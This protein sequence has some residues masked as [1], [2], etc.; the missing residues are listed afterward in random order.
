MI[1]SDYVILPKEPS[2]WPDLLALQLLDSSRGIWSL[3]SASWLHALCISSD[4]LYIYHRGLLK[5]LWICFHRRSFPALKW[6]P[7]RRW[8][9]FGHLHFWHFWKLGRG[10]FRHNH[11]ITFCPSFWEFEEVTWRGFLWECWRAWN[12]RHMRGQPVFQGSLRQKL[13][14]TPK[15]R[16]L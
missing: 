4:R 7:K 10:R 12:G 2:S 6:N 3:S 8:P 9:Y 16:L 14:W 15:R 5:L 13:A 1:V 11:G